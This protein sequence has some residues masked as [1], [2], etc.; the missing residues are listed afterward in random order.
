M[1]WWSVTRTPQSA[2][3]VSVQTVYTE[4]DASTL[5][6]A[7]K[8]AGKSLRAIASEYGFPVNHADIERI[9]QGKFP[10][11]AAKRK[12]L[13]LPPVCVSCGQRVKP[14][15]VVPGWVGQAVENLLLLEKSSTTKDTKSTKENQDRVYSRGGK[16]VPA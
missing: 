10:H 6:H 4:Q 16:R 9:L 12:A 7:K 3:K 2:K 11:S 15:R 8:D 5:I 14:A 13:G 1:G